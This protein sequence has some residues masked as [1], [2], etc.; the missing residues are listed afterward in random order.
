MSK[1]LR[2]M[3]E[4]SKRP[5][6]FH[7][8]GTDTGKLSGTVPVSTTVPET[9][10]VSDSKVLTRAENRTVPVSTT[11]GLSGTVPLKLRPS[12]TIP[13]DDPD[14]KPRVRVFRAT[15]VEHGHTIGE[16]LVY[17]VLWRYSTGDDEAART[18]QIGYDR[19]ASLA[20]VNWKTA[21]ACLKGLQ[22]KLAIEVLAAE[23]S[24]ERTG[25]T[26]RVHSFTSILERR[27]AAGMEWVEK[28]RGVRFIS[29]SGTVPLSNT[30]PVSDTDPV[31]GTA[32]ETGA[33]AVPESGTETVPDSGTPLGNIRNIEE[34]PSSSSV[35]AV[36]EATRRYGIVL[37]DDAAR[38][39]IRRCRT[40]CDDATDE[41]IACFTDL[42]ISQLRNSR[43]VEN[44]VGMLIASVPAYFEGSCPE[45]TRRRQQQASER[46]QSREVART[47]LA[48]ASASESEREW[49][50]ATLDQATSTAAV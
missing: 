35:T 50:R 28:G 6:D 27:R 29:Q 40:A 41:E 4:L 15:R 14:P 33:E 11:V 37:D 5:S 18:I 49:A 8:A 44:W 2:Q 22:D 46:E 25:K 10:T 7:K 21:K 23:N 43:K 34:M 36:Q 32:P 24:N 3:M 48:D 12:P 39:L 26:Y 16:H 45:L 1:F 38:K 42:K 17:E 13:P 9:G 47:I 20:N 30:V 31:S 19:L